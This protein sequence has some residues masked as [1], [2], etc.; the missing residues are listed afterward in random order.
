MLLINIK[1]IF[2]DFII[3]FV[4]D[5]SMDVEQIIDNNSMDIEQI[6]DDNSMDVEQIIDDN[7]M[8]IEFNVLKW[9]NDC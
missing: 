3:N 6:I 1:L 2:N 7:S 5:N 4:N 8:D 9:T